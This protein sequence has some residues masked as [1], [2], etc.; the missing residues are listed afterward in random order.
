MGQ[1]AQMTRE[2][3]NKTLNRCL[4][5]AQEKKLYGRIAFMLHFQNGILQQIT[6]ID[7]DGNRTLTRTSLGTKGNG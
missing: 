6:D 5:E 7:N 4:D 1:A 2:E 3:A